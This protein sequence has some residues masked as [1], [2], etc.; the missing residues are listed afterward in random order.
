LRGYLEIDEKALDKALQD[1]LPAVKDLFGNDTDADLIVDS[2]FAYAVDA[3][4]K[5]FVE[6]GGLVQLKT[7]TIDTK[8]AQ[9]KRRIETIDRQL[10]S[11]EDE[12]K[13]KYGAMEGALNRM[14]RTSGSIDQFSDRNN[15]K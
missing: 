9:E 2:G 11:K 13:R 8:I 4:T 5:P 3:L 12:L 10:Q 14:E 1:R 15:N 7:G 6:I